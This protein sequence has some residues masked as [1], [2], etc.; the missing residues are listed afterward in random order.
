M[1]KE[2]I[3]DCLD[4]APSDYHIFGHMKKGLRGKRYAKDEEVKIAV[5]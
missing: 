1:Q 5:M 4:L 3:I 2:E